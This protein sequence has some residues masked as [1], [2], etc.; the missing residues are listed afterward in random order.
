[1]TLEPSFRIVSIHSVKSLR[2][3][4]AESRIHLPKLA[5][6]CGLGHPRGQCCS[7][8]GGRGKD[9]DCEASADAGPGRPAR[10][11]ALIPD[12]LLNFNALRTTQTLQSSK[13]FHEI[14][15]DVYIVESSNCRLRFIYFP[16]EAGLGMLSFFPIGMTSTALQ[17]KI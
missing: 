3:R 5:V 4:S 6:R 17:V 13:H 12:T 15:R 9:G 14:L 11:A 16:D 7:A 1:M 10:G 8:C 2:L